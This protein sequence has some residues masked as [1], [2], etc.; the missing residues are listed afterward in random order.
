[1][2]KISS[3]PEALR[4]LIYAAFMVFASFA[5]LNVAFIAHLRGDTAFG[6]ALLVP[7]IPALVG[8]IIL[9]AFAFREVAENVV[10]LHSK[11]K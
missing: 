11:G 9:I 10:S 7:M 5:I 2:M 3:Y 6:I 4:M 1:M 8:A